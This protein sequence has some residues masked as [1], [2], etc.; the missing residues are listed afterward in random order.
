MFSLTDKIKNQK[1]LEWNDED[2]KKT[3]E[4]R[5]EIKT[6]VLLKNPKIFYLF[7]LFKNACD[8]GISGM[9]KKNKNTVGIYSSKLNKAEF[10][11][12][13]CEKEIFAISKA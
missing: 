3:N 4:I 8:N 11:Y 1:P 10:N 2:D 7:E 12:S 13:I 6:N 5:K 9:L